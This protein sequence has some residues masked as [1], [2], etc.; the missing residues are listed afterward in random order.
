M[1]LPSIKLTIVVIYFFYNQHQSLTILILTVISL[2]FCP[3]AQPACQPAERPHVEVGDQPN[4]V[5]DPADVEYLDRVVVVAVVLEEWL[6]GGV[7]E[8]E[9][10]VDAEKPA[11]WHQHQQL[12]D[13]E[14]RIC[15]QVVGEVGEGVSVATGEHH[16]PDRQN[17]QVLHKV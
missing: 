3:K 11:K 1:K 2:L 5:G 15:G 13:E 9:V 12:E 8:G 17:H 14:G 6:A 16:R 4:C 7:A 10:E